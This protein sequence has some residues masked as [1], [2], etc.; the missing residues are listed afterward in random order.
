MIACHY[1]CFEMAT[2]GVDHERPRGFSREDHAV[3]LLVSNVFSVVSR[4]AACPIFSGVCCITVG[5]ARSTIATSSPPTPPYFN[6]PRAHSARGAHIVLDPPPVFAGERVTQ[7]CVHERGEEDGL[8][9]GPRSELTC[10]A[11]IFLRRTRTFRAS[12]HFRA[13]ADDLIAVEHCQKALH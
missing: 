3:G 8:V 13:C 6:T 1:Q 9:P 11:S 12:A 7:M 2:F 10:A 4:A 5:L